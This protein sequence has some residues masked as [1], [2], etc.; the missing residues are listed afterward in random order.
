MLDLT[1]IAR[2]GLIYR[3]T[4]L[5]PVAHYEERAALVRAA[6]QSL[7]GLTDEERGSLRSLHLAVVRARSEESLAE[8]SARTDNRWSLEKLAVAN[9]L[10][11]TARLAEGEL[12][13]IAV[14][15]PYAPW[16]SQP[17]GPAGDR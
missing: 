4:G 14:E 12:L 16:E 7:R 15:R 1:F 5:V 3:I 2:G 8:L 9:A 10:S 11:P 13:K 17:G 6:A